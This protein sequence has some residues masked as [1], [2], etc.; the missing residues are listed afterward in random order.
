MTIK[1]GKQC[2]SAWKSIRDVSELKQWMDE[3]CK[4][5]CSRQSLMKLVAV[6]GV[7]VFELVFVPA[8]DVFGTCF[9]FRTFYQVSELQ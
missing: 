8:M 6:N 2:S 4:M 5:G 1:S 9:N 7:N 3:S